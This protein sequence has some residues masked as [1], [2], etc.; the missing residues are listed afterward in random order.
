MDKLKV[1]VISN[2]GFFPAEII[3]FQLLNSTQFK[4]NQIGEGFNPFPLQGHVLLKSLKKISLFN[5]N[6][7]QAFGNCTIQVSDALPNLMEINI[8]YCN[9]L[10]DFVVYIGIYIRIGCNNDIRLESIHL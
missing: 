2:Y 3:N 10:V 5:C 6:I 7:G 1:L 9:D 4:E 8:D